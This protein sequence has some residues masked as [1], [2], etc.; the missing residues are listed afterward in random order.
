MYTENIGEDGYRFAKAFLTNQVA[1]FAPKIYMNLTHETGR[2]DGGAE[3][4]QTA[5]YFYRCFHDY[6]ERLGLDDDQFRNFLK[7]KTVLEYGPGDIL[8]V[9]LLMY[10]HGAD[11]VHCVDR[12]PREKI[13]KKNIETYNKILARLAP[14]QRSRAI[15]AFNDCGD[16]GSGFNP[17]IVRYSVTKDGLIDEKSAY[18]LIISRAVLE[19][20]NCLEMTILDMAHALKEDGIAIH[21]VDLKSHNLD[22]YQP[23]DFLTWPETIYRL[24]N[25]HKGRPNRWRV[26]KYKE[27]VNR[28]GLQFKTL[29]H[30]G[31]L[32]DEEIDRIRPKLATGFR[33]LPTEELTW[34]GFWMVL[35][36]GRS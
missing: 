16:P 22:R 30:T 2:G 28:S 8:G 15:H 33:D 5:D 29:A 21:N 20:V 31:K 17:S 36:R 27:C 3:P 4:S 10:A 7:G 24:M 26:D 34:L 32:N 1:R 25:S 18:D 11:F 35:E 12:F 23:F 9:S 13:S 6:G 19:H 14:E